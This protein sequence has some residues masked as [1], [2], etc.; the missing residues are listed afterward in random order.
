MKK[1]RVNLFLTPKLVA[2]AKAYLAFENIKSGKKSFSNFV[3]FL[4]EEY[5]KDKKLQ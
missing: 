1:V 4:I 5:L 2:Q 3:D